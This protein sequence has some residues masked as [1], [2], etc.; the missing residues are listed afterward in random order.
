[1]RLR[2]FF[3]ACAITITAGAACGGAQDKPPGPLG[4]HFDESFIAQLAMDDKQAVIKA[5]TDFNVA[6]MEQDK[7][8]A[9]ERESKTLL[10]VARN[11]QGAARLD[12]KSAASRKTAADTSADQTR[13]AAAAKEQ[14]GAE[15][16]R[17]AAEQRV[18]YLESY[19]RWLHALLRYTQHNTFWRES[20]QELAEAKLAQSKNI[21][22]KGFRLDDYA[23]QEADRSRRTVDAKAKADAERG[24]AQDERTKWLAIQGEADKTLGKKSEFPDP[25]APKP[26]P[27]GP[28]TAGGAGYTVGTD[29]SSSDQHV[30]APDD[31]TKTAPAP[32]P[33]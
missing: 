25:L 7:A 22:P 24:K 8:I 28:S 4:R 29:G 20:Q 3:F 31:P 1:M 2:R 10:D 21:Q 13:I 5:Q 19:Q 16:A 14:A 17:R 33:Q 23:G 30:P 27:T 6:K 9:D 32:A 12:E 15:L 18:K 26:E 11:E